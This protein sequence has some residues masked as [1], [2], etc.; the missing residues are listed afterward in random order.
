[1][2]QSLKL[3]HEQEVASLH[4]LA[5]AAL[6]QWDGDFVRLELIKY[7]ENAVFCATRSDGQR[8][9]LRVHRDGYHSEEA[10]R[11]EL[12][13]M[14]A[15]AADGIHVPRIIRT[16]DGEHL[17]QVHS[18]ELGESRYID[19]LGWLGGTRIGSAEK[20]LEVDADLATLFFETGAVAARIHQSSS[21]WQQ[22]N[23]FSRH[24]WDEEGL[25]GP[26]PFWG[27]YWEL[28]L[29]DGAQRELLQATRQAART[30][31]RRYGRNLDNFGM[32]HAD[33]VPENLLLDDAQL[34]LIDF[35]DAGFGWHM[36][37]LA[38]ALYFCLDDPRYAEI[39]TALL[40][41]YDSVKTLS[42]ADRAT[43]PLF[44]ALRGLTYLGWIH[45]RRESRTAEELAPLLIGR[46]CQLART[47]LEQRR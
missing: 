29:L 37:E 6:S 42:Q 40:D 5:L 31:L 3:D 34:H 10:L 20:G 11:S 33:L 8:S 4:R 38:T 1:M 13:W 7:R 43:L 35:D 18:E 22:P 39:E 28:D 32:I 26:Q 12:A 44:L 27:P 46:A 23:A 25:I 36:F 41:G 21:R 2:S 14:E 16:R 19:M 24:A 47:Y 15:L 9:A 30:D 17:A 45:T